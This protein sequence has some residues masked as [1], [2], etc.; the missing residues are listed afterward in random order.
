MSTDFKALRMHRPLTGRPI[1]TPA[2]GGILKNRLN[3]YNCQMRNE[4][5]SDKVAPSKTQTRVAHKIE[6]SYRV[7]LIK[8]NK[9]IWNQ[10]TLLCYE[11]ISVGC[12]GNRYPMFRRPCGQKDRRGCILW[13]L[14]AGKDFRT[15]VV[16]AA[17]GCVSPWEMVGN[18]WPNFI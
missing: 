18:D 6:R 4:T 15:Q 7:R 8:V 2:R 12:G 11:I 14:V 13:D 5:R 17:P 1:A 16:H 10:I 9:E 3:T